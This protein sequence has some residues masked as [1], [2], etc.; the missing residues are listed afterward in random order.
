MRLF[1]TH[2]MFAVLLSLASS[3][4][5]ALAKKAATEPRTDRQISMVSPAGDGDKNERPRLSISASQNSFVLDAQEQVLPW[6]EWH[7]RVCNG[8][9]RAIRKQTG[10]RWGSVVMRVSVGK[11]RQLSVT[12]LESSDERF[13]AAAKAGAESL[14]QTALLAFPLG[15]NR[16]R[17]EFDFHLRKGVMFPHSSFIEDDFESLSKQD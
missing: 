3:N 8:L 2:I 5:S 7:Q 12:L 10:L 11:E 4:C 6:R 1:R 14:D 17:M 15:S 9:G 16:Q 13:G